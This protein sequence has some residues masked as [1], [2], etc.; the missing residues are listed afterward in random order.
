MERPSNHRGSSSTGAGAGVGSCGTSQVMSPLAVLSRSSW[1]ERSRFRTCSHQNGGEER[2]VSLVDDLSCGGAVVV[3]GS[4]Y[5][6]HGNSSPVC[7]RELIL[8]LTGFRDLGAIPIGCTS[9]TV[10][11]DERDRRPQTVDVRAA[12]LGGI[13]KGRVHGRPLLA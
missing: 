10:G 6:G 13:N 3:R 5:D 7:G 11:K 1:R 4:A 8:L 9:G 12:E 2:Y